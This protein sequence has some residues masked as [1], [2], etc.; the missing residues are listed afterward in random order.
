MS[1][2]YPVDWTLKDLSSDQFQQINLVPNGNNAFIIITTYREKVTTHNLFD[3]L[4]DYINK[5]YLERISKGFT[6]LRRT[7]I[8]TTVRDTKIPGSR[9]SGIYNKRE[10]LNDI[11]SFKLN[12]RFF[13]L[14]YMRTK[15][16]SEKSDIAWETVLKTLSPSDKTSASTVSIDAD[17]DAVVNGRAI[18]LPKPFYPS[19]KPSS[20]IKYT[21]EVRV[22][23]DETG[24][25]VSAKGV[26]GNPYFY[27][28]AVL[29]AK[30]AEFT[31]LYLCDHPVSS[32]G[33]IVYTFLNQ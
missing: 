6:D 27:P 23:I 26:S 9:L 15:E 18:K 5:P 20:L 3:Q 14:I 22:V 10:S 17:N 21:V 2:K 1:F 24:K 12:D 11:F 8:C 29:A 13:N 4:R 32:S 19:V 16:S 30:K 31:P 28:S 7:E 25:V 33:I